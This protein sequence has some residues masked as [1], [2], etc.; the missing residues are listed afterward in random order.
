MDRS[1]GASAR[2]RRNRAL[3]IGGLLVASLCVAASVV[4]WNDLRVRQDAGERYVHDMSAGLARNLE[5]TLGNLDRAFTGIGA[6]LDAIRQRGP[7]ASGAL[8]DETVQGVLA[9]HPDL[10]DLALVDE[11]PGFATPPG[12][13]GARLQA[14]GPLPA[15]DGDGW[16]VPLALAVS[17]G[18]D[19]SPRWLLGHLRVA[20]L[21]ALLRELDLG[22]TGTATFV[23]RSGQIVTRSDP[24]DRYVGTDVRQSLLFTHGVNV[25]DAGLLKGHSDL[26]GTR[27]LIGFHALSRYPLIATV[28]VGREEL[29][30]GWWA[31][32]GALATGGLLLLLAWLTGLRMLV[33]GARRERALSA[34]IARSAG[35]ITHL[36]ARMRDVEA[37]YR[38]LYERH[39]LPALVY[40][41]D[42]LR[43]LA[44][45]DAAIAEYGY[46]RDAFLALDADAVVVDMDGDG[47]QH[48]VAGAPASHVG[49]RFRHRRRDGSTF[50]VT[51]YSS[52][53]RFLGR[54]ARLVLVVDTSDR[55]R[56][57]AERERSEARFQMVVR[58]TSD[59]IWDWDIAT[60]S[61]WWNDGFTTQYGWDWRTHASTIDQWS[62][63]LHPDD[64]VR[65]RRDLDAALSS[66]ATEWNAQYR[67]RCENGAY[68][69]VEDRGMILRDADGQ[70]VRAVGGVLDVTRRRRDEADLRLLRRAVE[71]TENGIVIADACADDQPIVYVNPAFSRI[72]GYTADDSIGRNCRFLQGGERDQPALPAIRDAIA[73]AHEVRVQL[74]NYRRDGSPFWNELRM[75]P[76][77]DQDGALTHFVGILNDIT[78]RR[79]AEETLAH[80]ATHDELT[81]LPNRELVMERLAEAV[82]HADASGGCVGLA[83][84]D[85]DDFKLINDSLGHASGDEVLRTVGRRLRAALQ[86]GDTVGRFGG[87][88]FVLV[89][90]A[91]GRDAIARAIDGVFAALS[92]PM[93]IGAASL[94]I[95]PSIGYC[96][97]PGDG[98]DPALLLR[99][100]DQ[101][102]Y[103]AKQQGRNCVVAYRDEFGTQASE[104]LALVSQLRDA[105]QSDQFAL[106]FQLQ[107]DQERR[108][109]GM[110]AL[111][112]WRHPERGLLTPDAFISVCEDSGLIV[113]IGRWVL[114]EAARHHR[115][116]A[117]HGWG[118]L[119]LAVNVSAAQFQQGLVDDVLSVLQDFQ[120]PAGILELELTESVVM[121]SPDNV[122][123]D[124]ATLRDAGVCIAIDDFGTGYS[125]LAYLKRL[126]LHRVKLDRSFVQDLG[127]DPDDEAICDAIIRMAQRLGLGTTAEGVETDLQWTWLAAHGC[128]ELQGYLFACPAPFGDVLALLERSGAP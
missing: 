1:D 107:F 78:E 43:M 111:L 75:A 128:E 84:V 89:M 108:P 90:N 42:T 55:E 2:R 94:Q 20:S 120:L 52:N 71:A 93:E 123:R 22:R 101:A 29:L 113:P 73:Q 95:T 5:L 83:F 61:V 79:R 28:G 30:A 66:G 85:L 97:H 48:E 59:A 8:A 109:V 13:D 82:T 110:E 92:Q 77:R 99:H 21:H 14:G 115:I 18:P 80:R 65:V 122:I 12:A 106:A 32:V 126:P 41:R 39:P 118:H 37:Q 105:L 116:L 69:S 124:M 114:R 60:G 98:D 9:R 67:L 56:V 63:L 6:D 23:H 3:L 27:R 15:K 49:R 112:R 91:T 86:P 54:P 57:E 33:T 102:M 47:I 34:D 121:A 16:V 58:A 127:R 17:D 40:D 35:A 36:T 50:A 46:P 19:G 62:A 44:V 24:G 25:A 26:D 125:S 70:P 31:F 11:R 53:L 38:Y 68:A 87:D 81:G 51:V 74:R 10:Q 117:A 7:D 76:V 64:E 119:R 96:R 4:A 100:A 104:R 103:Q 88:E 45:N 72:T